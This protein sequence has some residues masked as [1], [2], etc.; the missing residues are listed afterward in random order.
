MSQTG[1]T[2]RDHARLTKAGFL[3]GVGL[4]VVGAIGALLV[5]VIGISLPAWEV[6]LLF[7]LEVIGVVIALLS[8]FV[9]GVLLP[10]V[11]D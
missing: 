6:T 10:L 1:F 3:L 9:L 7:D 2:I 5:D 8:P 11:S 4:F